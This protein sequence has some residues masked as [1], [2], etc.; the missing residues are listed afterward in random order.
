MRVMS[1]ACPYFRISTCINC[2]RQRLTR[3]F[4]VHTP[5]IT[6]KEGNCHTS[7]RTVIVEITVCFC[8][9]LFFSNCLLVDTGVQTRA[10]KTE[11]QHESD[12]HDSQKLFCTHKAYL[13]SR[14]RKRARERDRE[15][16][17]QRGWEKGEDEC[18][19][20]PFLSR[21]PTRKKKEGRNE[22]RMMRKKWSPTEQER[23]PRSV[24]FSSRPRVCSSRCRM[25]KTWL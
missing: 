18:G 4:E 5:R 13:K 19:K 1:V 9:R 16:K 23:E 6:E 3:N 14:T 17:R 7:L 11:L 25:K 15:E 10:W 22:V 12:D 21:C 24:Y 20:A 2:K 8:S